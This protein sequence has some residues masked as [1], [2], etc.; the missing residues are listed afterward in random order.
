MDFIYKG[1]NISQDGVFE[2]A[3]RVE[4]VEMPILLGLYPDTKIEKPN[5]DLIFKIT[6][7]AKEGG[8]LFEA[9][10]EITPDNYHQI[11][12]FNKPLRGEFFKKVNDIITYSKKGDKTKHYL[13]E[14]DKADNM[15]LNILLT[16]LSEVNNNNNTI[17]NL[18]EATTK[19]IDEGFKNYL[20]A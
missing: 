10:D 19:K 15:Y 13:K 8:F 4:N 12:S 11:I 18:G 20:E 6:F 17:I 5:Y 14:G 1:H 3:F 9:G 16:H 2:Y 7:D